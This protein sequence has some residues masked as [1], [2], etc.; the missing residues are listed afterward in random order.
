MGDKPRREVAVDQWQ[1]VWRDEVSRADSIR[2]YR[3]VYAG[4]IAL[5]AG[6]S[7]L[8]VEQ[9]RPSLNE[10]GWFLPQ[11]LFT[12]MLFVLLAAGYYLYT[13]KPLVRV[14]WAGFRRRVSRFAL[15]CALRLSGRSVYQAPRFFARA[16][17]RSA[18]RFRSV[19]R[20]PVRANRLLYVLDQEVEELS[21]L[22]AEELSEW[23]AMAIA[24]ASIEL[25]EANHRVFKR[26]GTG[27]RL[28]GAAYLFASVLLV[29]YLWHPRIHNAA[30]QETKPAQIESQSADTGKVFTGRGEG[31]SQEPREGTG[32]PPERGIPFNA[33]PDSDRNGELN[34]SSL[35]I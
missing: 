4:L 2:D 13:E 1:M 33:R 25:G 27:I 30:F 7:V 15:W 8:R 22:S 19:S 28:T 20:I 21:D 16:A 9:I 29:W 31:A 32:C 17:V 12:L 14:I 3:K 18:A 6:A 35:T 34:P 5:L 26:I 11:A 23:H 10:L 24:A